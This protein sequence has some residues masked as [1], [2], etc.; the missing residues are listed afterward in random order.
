MK[1]LSRILGIVGL[2]AMA[3]GFGVGLYT[4]LFTTFYVLANLG[5]G[6]LLVF[7]ALIF[8]FAEMKVFITGRSSRDGANAM[9]FA[10]AVIASLVLIN[11][12]ASKNN[13]RWDLTEAK[14][15]SLAEASINLTRDLA[16]DVR[17][18]GFFVGGAAGPYQDLLENYRYHN[19]RRFNW[20]IVDPDKR[21]ELA[22][23]YTIRAD[24]T[25]VVETGDDRRNLTQLHPAT[26]EESLS[27]AILNLTSSGRKTL[28]AVQGHGE[29][30]P[31]DMETE[32]G[33]AMAKLELGGE[34]YD[35]RPWLIATDAQVPADCS[36]VLIAGPERP[37]RPGAIDTLDRYLAQGGN[38]MVMLQPRY[39]GPLIELLG[40]WGVK[41]DDDIVVDKV[42]RMFEGESLGLQPIVTA[43]DPAH[44]ITRGF[45]KQTVFNHVRSVR[46]GEAPEGYTVTELARTG[47]G[48][49]AE[50]DL[51]TLFTTGDAAKDARDLP[52][53]VSVAVAVGPSGG[54]RAGKAKI[55]VFGTA[56]LAGNRYLTALF[57]SDLFLNSA[58]WLIDM[59][60]QISIRP[61]TSRPSFVRLTDE[62]M[63]RIFHLAV[64]IFPQLLLTLG[65][66]VAWRRR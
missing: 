30:D 37:Y 31:E 61:K 50:S 66:V 12:I 20:E 7:L 55:V 47:P 32:R 9:V 48:S 5:L 49:W 16:Q 51:E 54:E 46:Q 29:R 19:P 52:G 3:F 26:F 53:P 23:K 56:D 24:A 57:N 44:P 28:C 15:Y 36:I 40:K 42:M 41:L 11:F 14:Q 27:N 58:N 38:L 63:A 18:I 39:G 43:Y 60:K 6:G 59:E 35:V 45:Q 21:P 4:G 10:L 22:D 33:F 25:F 13:K 34:N 2:I 65:I 62:E 17:V 64:L 1:S 8:N